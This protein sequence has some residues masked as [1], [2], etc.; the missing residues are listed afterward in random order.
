MCKLYLLL[1]SYIFLS[2]FSVRVCYFRLFG[3]YESFDHAERVKHDAHLDLK[4]ECYLDMSTTSRS[5]STSEHAEHEHDSQHLDGVLSHSP[6][7]MSEDDDNPESNTSAINDARS[8]GEVTD[9]DEG[10]EEDEEEEDDEDD[11]DE[12][13]LKYERLGT[14]GHELFHKDSASALTYSNKRLASQYFIEGSL[15]I[16]LIVTCCTRL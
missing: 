9:S 14:V 7:P 4:R 10:S 1:G 16:I 13:A 2:E 8:D 11:D 6:E 12:P 15:S 5:D 3:Q